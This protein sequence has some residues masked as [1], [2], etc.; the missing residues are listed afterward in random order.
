MRK[1]G[2]R[3][4]ARTYFDPN[5]KSIVPITRLLPR[6]R[7]PILKI[8]CLIN[9]STN[10]FNYAAFQQAINQG[11]ILV[12]PKTSSSPKSYRSIPSSVLIANEEA[13]VCDIDF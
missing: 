9:F 7:S 1:K 5:E 10:F 11:Q 12:S 2:L 13:V 3:L 6:L 4:F 8:Q